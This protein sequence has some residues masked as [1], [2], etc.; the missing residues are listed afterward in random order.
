VIKIVWTE[1]K[2]R[3]NEQLDAVEKPDGETFF[4]YKTREKIKKRRRVVSA[5]GETVSPWFDIPEEE[6][7]SD[8]EA[9]EEEWRNQGTNPRG[10]RVKS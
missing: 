10:N 4:R 8:I 5:H 7:P 2:D 9:F 1:F 6:T 3:V